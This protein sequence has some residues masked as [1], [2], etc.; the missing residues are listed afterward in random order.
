MADRNPA[1]ATGPSRSGSAVPREAEAER[2]YRKRTE[3]WEAISELCIPEDHVLKDTAPPSSF[4]DTCTLIGSSIDGKIDIKPLLSNRDTASKLFSDF[5]LI[6]DLVTEMRNHIEAAE[7][8]VDRLTAENDNLRGARQ[9]SVG[10]GSNAS[11][12]SPELVE[13]LNKLARRSN[14]ERS[15]KLPD[16]EMFSGDPAE[17]PQFRSW[18]TDMRN[19]M[20]V[21]QDHFLSSKA[22]VA[23][24]FSR[25]TG[26]ANT[27]LRPYIETNSPQI[28]TF[29]NIIRLLT[30]TFDDPH[31]VENK[32]Q[33]FRSLYQRS[34]SFAE[35]HANFITLATD[36]EVSQKDWFEEM[37]YRLSDEMRTHLI[38]QKIGMSGNFDTLV[39]HCRDVDR[40][41]RGI[42][43]RKQRLSVRVTRD[44]NQ[45]Q[46]DKPRT[47]AP[48]L[49]PTFSKDSGE[50]KLERRSH[51][52]L[53]A[54][55]REGKCFH[56]KEAGHMAH[57]CFKKKALLA[58]ME[59]FQNS[60]GKARAQL[61]FA[62]EILADS[63]DSE[64]E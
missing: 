8:E 50:K 5:H 51:Q 31:Y 7:D 61:S 62:E 55:R 37:W 41:M 43:E 22:K 46:P 35:F 20:E 39:T 64:N 47:Y 57:Q 6:D 40:E 26:W 49:A 58:T 23:Y 24:V 60:K 29:E 54:L 59:E 1:I 33:Q 38:S 56:C 30:D 15:A 18:K 53:E 25:T 44:P 36:A 48:R 21:N 45:R 34:K 14:R 3:L 42:N 19:K 13:I 32:K 16:P 63:S 17:K 4:F 27:I 52:E 12:V 11:N 10:A 9:T 28:S 2:R